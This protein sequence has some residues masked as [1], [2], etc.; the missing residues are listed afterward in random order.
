M[1]QPHSPNDNPILAAWRE[2][3]ARANKNPFLFNLLLKQW[4]RVLRRLAYFYAQLASLPR[5]NRRALQRAL[6][7]SLIGAAMILAL[8]GAPIVHAAAI[9]VDPGAAGINPIDGC[10]LV[11]AIINANTDTATY[12]ECVGGSGADTITLPASATL[13]YLTYYGTI[14]AL[15]DVVTT[16]TIEGNNSTIQRNPAATDEFN[17]FL[18]RPD[19]EVGDLTLKDATIQGGS[20]LFIF[21]GG[22]VLNFTATLTLDN[23]VITGNIASVGGG[24]TN[25]GGVTSIADSEVSYNAAF[26][27]GGLATVLGTT[28]V[29]DSNIH[30]NYAPT[31]G[32]GIIL[33][34]ATTNVNR[35]TV[36]GNFARIG[37]GIMS[38]YNIPSAGADTFLN[39][40]D[41]TVSYNTA[42]Y[43]GGGIFNGQDASM[44]LTANQENAKSGIKFGEL[45]SRLKELRQKNGGKLDSRAAF[46][47]IRN[48]P[49]LRVDL[50]A[51]K[52][53][54]ASGDT[55]VFKRD[56]SAKKPPT[57]DGHTR[58]PNK[59]SAP[60]KHKRAPNKPKSSPEALA[61]TYTN[62][63]VINQS[64]INNNYAQYYGGG[65]SNHYGGQLTL[66]NSTISTNT[67]QLA[68][69]GGV[70]NYAEG[71][72]LSVNTTITGNYAGSYGGGISNDGASMAL[73][74]TIVSGNT[75]GG[76]DGFEVNDQLSVSTA[77]S[78]SLF[79]HAGILNAQAFSGFTPDVTDFNATSDGDGTSTHVPAALGSI[80][81]PT[82]AL[83]SNPNGTL[84]HALPLGSPALD[85]AP[86]TVCSSP[87]INDVDQRGFPRNVDI[88]PPPTANDCDIGAFELQNATA[89]N[90]MGLR[91]K[92]NERGNVAL[93]WRTTSETHIAGFNVYRRNGQG[94]WKQINANFKQAKHAGDT[95]GDKYRY[96]DKKAKEGNVYRYKIEVKY[97]DGHHEW[98]EVVRVE[99]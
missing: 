46:D 64:T 91:A 50:S 25:Y 61:A 45:R 94:E 85:K 32:G 49:S 90:V 74:I 33:S 65:I 98:T 43:E 92:I 28:T 75:A 19:V 15:P 89:V 22:G 37:G 97:L 21:G 57:Q 93:K 3:L 11:E 24:I 20:L 52:A 69:G 7:T 5:R 81:D 39:L 27:G 4:Q 84:T 34:E 63:A 1:T 99:K 36:S 77:S 17:L 12:A 70:E 8:S 30:H 35:S 26:Y 6:A 82:L 48:D 60:H 44:L 96:V 23:C 2:Q 41:T 76:V 73:G 42:S 62:F 40:D 16:I 87:I 88:V 59:H 47:A 95:Q 9:T 51:L 18:V 78:F 86:N 67:A 79:G 66:I 29:D 56:P 58:A 10:S 14:S 72:V 71:E 68:L 80:L 83:N 13:D 38:Y 55:K 54:R 31:L 53:S